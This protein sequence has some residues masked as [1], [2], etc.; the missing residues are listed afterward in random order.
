MI[1]VVFWDRKEP[2]FAN[3]QTWRAV[4]YT[5]VFS[6]HSLLCVS[7]KLAIALG[8]LVVGMV[9]YTAVELHLR[10][11]ERRGRPRLADVEIN[12]PAPPSSSP[13]SAGTDGRGGSF[14][15][16][17]PPPSPSTAPSDLQQSASHSPAARAEDAGSVP[18]LSSI[19]FEDSDAENGAEVTLDGTYLKR[20]EN[21]YLDNDLR[22]YGVVPAGGSRVLTVSNLTASSREADERWAEKEAG[23]NWNSG[24]STGLSNQRPSRPYSWHE[25]RFQDE[26]ELKVVWTKDD[27][28]VY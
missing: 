23:G 24:S 12:Y 28:F 3:Y 19:V 10:W 5:L 20:G 16:A 11:K 26:G 17:P 15:P 25:Q 27:V 1:A 2:A 13:V 21:A 22:R 14:L 7:S 4:G 18:T 9:L 6:F 8:F